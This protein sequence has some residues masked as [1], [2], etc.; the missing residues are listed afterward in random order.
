MNIWCEFILKSNNILVKFQ[1]NGG[2][3]FISKKNRQRSQKENLFIDLQDNFFFIIETFNI[4]Y[5]F[6][7]LNALCC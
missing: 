3:V 5:L 7:S 6:V 2:E 1:K 4:N